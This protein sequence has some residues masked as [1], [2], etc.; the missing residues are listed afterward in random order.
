MHSEPLLVKSWAQ[1]QA[2]MRILALARVTKERLFEQWELWMQKRHG[3]VAN[4]ASKLVVV[5]E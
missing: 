1:M 3:V 2:Q 4:N 5:V